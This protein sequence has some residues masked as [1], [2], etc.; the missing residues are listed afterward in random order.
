MLSIGVMA[1]G[2]G[3]YYQGLAQEDYYLEG[4][5]PVGKWWGK[6]AEHFKLEGKKVSASTLEKLLDGF[7]PKGAPFVQNAGDRANSTRRP[8]F[9]LTFSAPKTVS[10]LWAL[11]TPEV[12]A[13]IQ[14]AQDAA[15]KTALGYL[16]RSGAFTRTGKGGV[17]IHPAGLAVALFEHGTSRAGDPQLHTHALLMNLGVFDGGRIRAIIHTEFFQRKMAAGAIY[18]TALASELEKRLGIEVEQ[19]PRAYGKGGIG[20][21]VT[22][23]PDSICD[24]WSKRRD[25]IEKQLGEWGVESAS[26]AAAATRKTRG[27][28]EVVPPRGELFEKWKEEA[29]ALGIEALPEKRFSRRFERSEKEVFDEALAKTLRELTAAPDTRV[30][31]KTIGGRFVL[32][33]VDAFLAG[34]KERAFGQSHFT[35]TV[36]LRR[37]AEN[38]QAKGISGEFL[39][40]KFAETL[41]TSST[42]IQL[43]KSKTGE[44][45]L[46]T[47]DVLKLETEMLNSAKV[48]N[49]NKVHGV[50]SALIDSTIE[51]YNRKHPD[52]L[53]GKEREA[54]IRYLT[55]REGGSIRSLEGLAGTAKTTALSIVRELYEKKGYQVIGTAVAGKAVKELRQSGAEDK[56]ALDAAKHHAKQYWRA[57]RNK[58]TERYRPVGFEKAVTLKLFEIA[59]SVGF[60]EAF[61]HHS[62][63]VMRAYFKRPTYKYEPLKLNAKTVVICDE[64]SMVDTRQMAM[65]TERVKKGGGL[66]I[67]AGDRKQIQ[68]IGQGGGFARI[69]DEFGKATLTEIVRQKNK[70]DREAVEAIV[71]G[72]AKSVLKS[73]AD[74]NLLAVEK[75]KAAAIE[76]LVDDWVKSE[77]GNKKDKSLIFVGT[78]ADAAAV[79]QKCQE[80]RLNAGEISSLARTTSRG[81]TFHRGDRVL[82]QAKSR[83][84][85]VENGETGTIVAINPTP[86][87]KTLTIKLD[88]GEKVVV[89]LHDY[90][91]LSLGYAVTTHKGQ[92]STVDRAYVLLGGVMQDKE[93][94][95]V[96]VSRA[97]EATKLYTTQAEAG[98]EF[99]D[100]SKQMDRSNAKALADTMLALEMERQRRLQ[101]EQQR[102]LQQ[103]MKH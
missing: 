7:T 59:S 73:F 34:E 62:R 4:G 3:H 39:L 76:R 1:G 65:L 75:D 17:N 54:A 33:A 22:G 20:F 2:Q 101:E 66:L 8:G 99:K 38:C 57:A 70:T 71:E 100:L 47:T 74:R 53:L 13:E 83:S 21:K 14:A 9:D 64:A 25:E 32:K 60:R 95:Y 55:G 41:K 63:Q 30:E 98:V 26:A 69:A 82:F 27:V 79:N 37:L 18:R 6:G 84:I 35:E 11:S 58:S 56:G 15:V 10:A 42:L 44:L 81:Q 5:E 36:L 28:K 87:L 67:L 51:K 68:A 80:E 43:G 29:K 40:E 78:N 97:R 61:A 77:R 92:G 88:D 85:G 93:L 19:D 102:S 91:K 94:S 31:A 50:P 103:T 90:K 45:T 52:K 49:S 48:L 46:T 72:K 24:F 23:I 89:P 12:R 86:I 96:Q 16:E